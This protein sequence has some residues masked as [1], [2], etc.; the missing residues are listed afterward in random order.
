MVDRVGHVPGG[1]D[2]APGDPEDEQREQPG[3]GEP[4]AERAARLR[5]VPWLPGIPR[6]HESRLRDW[7]LRRRGVSHRVYISMPAS[8]YKAIPGNEFRRIGKHAA[9]VT[10]Q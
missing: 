7:Q 1:D 6:W 10:L 9:S 3:R 2:Q 5:R 4:V 8:Y